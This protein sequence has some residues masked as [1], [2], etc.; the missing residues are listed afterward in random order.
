MT[1]PAALNTLLLASLMYFALLCGGFAT[2]AI[3]R[4]TWPG[5]LVVRLSHPPSTCPNCGRRLNWLDKFPLA[6]WL[7]RGGRCA[8][9]R[10]AIP[11][12]YPVTEAAAACTVFA[13]TAPLALGDRATDPVTFTLHA[14]GGA[15]A[16]ALIALAAGGRACRLWSALVGA[17]GVLFAA[18]AEDPSLPDELRVLGVVACGV[19]AGVTMRHR[20]RQQSVPNQAAAGWSLVALAGWSPIPAMVI[21]VG[22]TLCGIWRRAHAANGAGDLDTSV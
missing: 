2:V 22:V 12:A 14:L 11:L 15:W 8:S 13:I 10:V 1:D 5:T 3:S 6:G 19:L 7:L 18:L 16:V 17:L 9:C 20:P 4:A 21:A